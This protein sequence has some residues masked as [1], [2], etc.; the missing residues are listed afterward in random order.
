MNQQTI[1]YLKEL[2]FD[3]DSFVYTSWVVSVLGMVMLTDFHLLLCLV[4]SFF[5]AIPVNIAMKFIC[6][7]FA[8]FA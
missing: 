4:A 6:L 3:T 1:N 2:A 8:R 5:I 7:L